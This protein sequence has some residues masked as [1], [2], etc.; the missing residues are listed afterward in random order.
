M[1]VNIDG[2]ETLIPTVVGGK[3]LSEDE[4]LDRYYKTGLHMGQFNTPEEADYAS[5]LRTARYNMLEDPIRF[6]ADQ[7]QVGG[8]APIYT[9]NP[10]DPRLR[11]Y[12][13]STRLYEQSKY[14]RNLN[15][16][17]GNKVFTPYKNWKPWVYDPIDLKKRNA[18]TKQN[19]LQSQAEEL[20]SYNDIANDI[21]K[22]HSTI[23]PE[24]DR[25]KRDIGEYAI[26][27][28]SSCKVGNGVEQ[29]R[30]DNVNTFWQSDGLQPHFILIQFLKK[31]R[32]NEI[33]IYLDYKTD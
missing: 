10:N 3:Q 22:R 26:W 32:V 11:S 6:Q 20:S 9:S 12:N 23:K 24:S 18:L 31:I 16:V 19:I 2:R 7:F 1:G 17:V 8:R 33:W 15:S 13:D 28:L 14:L 27:S 4:A 5:R 25:F 21:K 30:D 29:L